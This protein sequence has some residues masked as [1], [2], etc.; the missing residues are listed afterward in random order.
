MNK[1]TD[2]KSTMF[3]YGTKEQQEAELKKPRDLPPLVVRERS[4]QKPFP[5]PKL[6]GEKEPSAPSL[7][8]FVEKWGEAKQRAAVKAL[9]AKA[10]KVKHFGT[11]H[12]TKDPKGSLA[13]IQRFKTDEGDVIKPPKKEEKRKEMASEM[14]AHHHHHLGRHP[15]GRKQAIAIGL[16]QAGMSRKEKSMEST[17]TKGDPGGM[18]GYEKGVEMYGKEGMQKM[19]TQHMTAGEMKDKATPIH[20]PTAAKSVEDKDKAARLMPDVGPA[21]KALKALGKQEGEEAVAK[22]EPDKSMNKQVGGGPSVGVGAGS[23]PTGGSGPPSVG[24]GSL[25]AGMGKGVGDQKKADLGTWTPSGF[26]GEGAAP[27]GYKPAGDPS[28]AKPYH[29]DPAKAEAIGE[30]IQATDPK[31]VSSMG[32]P[33]KAKPEAPSISGSKPAYMKEAPSKVTVATSGG[34]KTNGGV[35]TSAGASPPSLPKESLKPGSTLTMT[36]VA[37]K[38]KAEQ[39]ASMG[40]ALQEWLMNKTGINDLMDKSV[41]CHGGKGPA[42]TGA[43]S[44]HPPNKGP[45]KT[46]KGSEHHPGK[47]PAQRS[48]DWD[49][50]ENHGGKGRAKTGAGTPHHPNRGPAK[51][52]AGKPHSPAKEGMNKA[53][54]ARGIPKVS[55]AMAQSMDTW[56]SATNVLTRTNAMLSPQGFPTAEPVV[57]ASGRPST[58]EG[59][60]KSDLSNCEMCGR[61]FAKSH[62]DC[63]TCSMNKALTCKGC[64]GHMVKGHGGMKCSACG[65]AAGN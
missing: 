10:K 56:R 16:G 19:A 55:R 54:T 5:A 7:E 58:Y 18:S 49:E 36:S 26:T 63:P 31:Q 8:A 43:G 29:K 59:V 2:A 46:G 22:D 28:T 27:K 38:P 20:L 17:V 53:M 42:K 35:L 21:I 4:Q 47:G 13:R 62:G 15:G 52:G 25:A 57:D 65:M 9:L 14:I 12:G 51:T 40:K 33:P 64:G 11:R 1:G 45:A 34:G 37:G 23:R 60:Y 44:P 50:E 3:E 6:P 61:T 32:A 48:V 41:A 30:K 39:A 24:A